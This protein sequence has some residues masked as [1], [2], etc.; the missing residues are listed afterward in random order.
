MAPSLWGDPKEMG[1]WWRGRDRGEKLYSLHTDSRTCIYILCV[2]MQVYLRHTKWGCPKKKRKTDPT[3]YCTEREGGSQ[4]YNTTT[5]N[6]RL[7]NSRRRVADNVADQIVPMWKTNFGG[8]YKTMR[9]STC[10]FPSFRYCLVAL[11]IAIRTQLGYG[12]SMQLTISW[13]IIAY[14]CE[15]PRKLNPSRKRA[16]FQQLRTG[17][18][19]Q[20]HC[21]DGTLQTFQK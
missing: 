2:W 13:R 14:P 8:L 3:N 9:K 1:G 18:F 5:I 11:L 10:D 17:W 21:V 7:Y 4:F 6:G 19:Q 16:R 15:I 20:T 12:H